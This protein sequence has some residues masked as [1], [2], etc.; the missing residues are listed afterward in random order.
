MA[1]AQSKSSKSTISRTLQKN[2]RGSA[3]SGTLLDEVKEV[4]NLPKFD[5][6]VY[7]NHVDP[8]SIQLS[9]EVKAQM[10]SYVTDIAG[11]YSESNS[12]H[13]FDHAS[14]VMMS[15]IKLMSR[16]NSPIEVSMND[17]TSN[18]KIAE[19]L[20]DHTFGITSDPLT[21]FS[22]VLAAMIHDVDHP[23]VPN[24][25]LVSENDPISIKYSGKSVAEQN[26]VEL[27][28][29]RLMLPQYEA[30]RACIYTNDEELDRFRQTLLQLVLATDVIDKDLGAKRKDRW[31]KAFSPEGA[32]ESAETKEDATNRKA[33]I[34][35]EH[36]L[37]ASDVSHTMQHWQ[38]YVKWNERLFQEMYSGYKASRLAKNPAEAWYEGELGFFDY[39]IIPLAKKLETC[40]VFGV[41]S[42]E[43]LSYASMNREEWKNKGRDIVKQYLA[44]IKAEE[45]GRLEGSE[46]SSVDTDVDT[47][48]DEVATNDAAPGHKIFDV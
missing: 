14:H 16:I 19:N 12:F 47:F 22:V 44:N 3:N 9:D 6:K 42:H 18:H 11:M 45:A 5:P 26:S 23:G 38:V 17:G 24:S 15:V 28:W 36:L 35:L 37:Q 39:Y 31:A 29:E 8:E 30:L 2:I 25:T 32:S 7:T 4:L 40:G 27:A 1:R 43:Y 48:T 33:T 13:C 41:S 10:I 34:V 21:Q 46:E 20:H